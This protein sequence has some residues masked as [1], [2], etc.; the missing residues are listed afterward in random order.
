MHIEARR[1]L[2]TQVLGARDL[3]DV[4]AATQALKEWIQTYPEEQN[5]MR[6]GFEQLSHMEDFARERAAMS[7][8]QRE[9][10]QRRDRLIGQIYDAY[11][12]PDVAVASKAVDEWLAAYPED[13]SVE[14]AQRY[15]MTMQELLMSIAEQEASPSLQSAA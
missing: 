10:Y 13:E 11:T 2:T 9:M 8:E 3:E 14:T 7:P 6:D 4:L 5:Y 12:L 15:L 1:R